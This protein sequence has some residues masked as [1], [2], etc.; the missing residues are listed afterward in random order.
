[1]R[2]NS[3]GDSH[4]LPILSDTEDRVLIVAELHAVH[5][6][7]VSLPAQRA[8]IALHVCGEM[9]QKETFQHSN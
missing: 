8:L 6:T 5:F 2:I 9:Q 3:E 7:V 1:M 4:H